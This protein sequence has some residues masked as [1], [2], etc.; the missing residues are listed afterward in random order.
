MGNVTVC[1]VIVWIPF[2]AIRDAPSPPAFDSWFATATQQAWCTAA[3]RWADLPAITIPAPT[4]ARRWQHKVTRV[5]ETWAGIRA[6]S[7]A[8]I[9]TK[10]DYRATG[11]KRYCRRHS[12]H[13][14][15][16]GHDPGTPKLLK[17]LRC[18]WG[19]MIF[20]GKIGRTNTLASLCD[21]K[22]QQLTQPAQ[23]PVFKYLI[24]KH[25]AAGAET[26]KSREIRTP[27]LSK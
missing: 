20:V 22:W 24:I 26:H 6:G 18:L 27:S 25:A 19:D 7:W 9:R 8:W 1:L 21:T 16:R 11:K 10:T 2:P 12:V 23:R 4:F 15:V 13:D 5:G 3:A 14:S 17:N